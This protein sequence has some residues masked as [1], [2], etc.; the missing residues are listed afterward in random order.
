M[1]LPA[2][3]PSSAPPGPRKRILVVED[4]P[5]IARGLRDALEFEGFDVSAVGTGREGVDIVRERAPDLIILDLM[6]PDVNGFVVCEQVRASH[7]TLP[8]IML[9]ARSQEADKIRG[10]EVGA[11]DY[12]TKPFSVGELVA[13]IGA[14]FRRLSRTAAAG[15]DEAIQ[16]GDATV[17]LRRHELLRNKRTFALSF[18]EVEIVRLLHE[19]AGQP[20]PREELL[21]KIWGVSGASQTRSVDNFVVKLRKKIEENA[22]QPRHIVTIYGMGYKLVP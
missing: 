17:F 14:I 19:R 18:Y 6:L 11:D 16:I 8:I 4:E 3:P 10:L 13:R 15:Q 2:A 21:E 9:T 12:V 7:P 20:V 5:D 22:S 1:T